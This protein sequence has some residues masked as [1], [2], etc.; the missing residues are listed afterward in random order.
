MGQNQKQTRKNEKYLPIRYLV[1]FLLCS[2]C[3]VLEIVVL[4]NLP[5][6]YILKHCRPL[7]FL[8]C[9]I[10]VLL[11]VVGI[12]YLYKGK[13]AIYKLILSVYGLTIFFLV[14]FLLADSFGLIE[15]LRDPDRYEKFLKEWGVLLPVVYIGLQ[16]IQVLFLP[17]PILFSILTGLRLFGLIGTMFYVFIGVFLGSIIAFLIG[18]K[19]GN[20][21]VSWLIGA[22]KLNEWQSKLRGKDTV[23]ISA[24]LLLPF[25]PDDLLCMLAGLS[26]ITLP[27]FI[28][29]MSCTRAISVLAT[30]LSIEYIPMNTWWGLAVWA[31]MFCLLGIAFLIVYK[32]VGRSNNKVK[33]NKRID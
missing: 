33:K 19:W 3:V 13:E 27:R 29:M 14:I 28:V 7:L 4:P 21:G 31:G 10:T 18:R 8:A 6:D 5:I 32:S 1:L 22:E 25:F 30:C 23:L 15:I 11:L 12:I 16:V 2:V 17:V 24:M 20:K 9:L 26:T